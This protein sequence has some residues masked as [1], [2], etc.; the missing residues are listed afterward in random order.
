MKHKFI[1]KKYWNSA[2]TPMGEVVDLAYRYD[3]IINLS[4]GDPDLITDPEIINE[5]FKDAHN[6]HTRYA[7]S[8]GDPE[9]RREIIRYYDSKYGYQAGMNELMAVVGACHGMFLVLEAILDEG[10]EVIVPEPFFTPYELQIQLAGGRLIPLETREEDGYQID[11]DRLESLITNRTKAIIINTPNNPTGA[12][13]KGKTME[14]LAETAIANDLIVIADDVYGLFSFSEPFTPMT[15]LAGMKERTVTIGSFSKDYTM[16]GWRI[17]YVLAPDYLISCIRDINEGV[18]FSAPSLSQRAAI[19]ALRLRDKVQPV[20]ISEYKE[21]VFYA[22]DR[23]N[24][25]PWMSVN[26]P[27]GSFY[28]FPNI[29]KT[30]LTSMDI[31]RRILEEAHVLVVPGNAFGKSGE[32]YIRIACTVETNKLIEAFDRIEKMKLF[33]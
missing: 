30:G 1:S 5:A 32:G 16:T 11:V 13:L 17:G 7:D 24:R 14:E 22:Y 33:L 21:R 29:K 4:L 23:I 9:L 27:Q 18:C 3:D 20:I 31:S 2:A 6:G 12:C 26:P 10:D 8:V 19:H 25:I 28:L 15:T